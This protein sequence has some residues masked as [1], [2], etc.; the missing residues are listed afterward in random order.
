MPDI[1]LDLGRLNDARS[2]LAAS[3]SEFEDAAST[4]D[5][6]EDDIGKP[7][8]RGELRD[9][10]SDFESAWD[11]KRETLQENLQSILDQL[12]EI[13]TNWTE[14][15]VATAQSQESGGT[16]TTTRQAF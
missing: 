8:D 11:G 5:G 1:M 9:K 13:V 14:W 16:S 10:A 15:D 6:L 12:D 3:I 7:D 2:D 4:N